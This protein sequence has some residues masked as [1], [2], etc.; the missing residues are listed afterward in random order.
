MQQPLIGHWM[1]PSGG[2]SR[3]LAVSEAGR[4]LVLGDLGRSLFSKDWA[5]CADATPLRLQLATTGFSDTNA[6]RRLTLD[7]TVRPRGVLEPGS[8]QHQMTRA[9]L[10][11]NGRYPVPRPMQNHLHNH[12]LAPYC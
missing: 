5:S 2:E 11:H 4:F 1:R 6:R 10:L 9:R 3:L 7:A 8:L 12:R